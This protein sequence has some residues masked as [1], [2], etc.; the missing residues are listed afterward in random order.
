VGTASAPSRHF[1]RHWFASMVLPDSDVPGEKVISE[2][3]QSLTAG[4]EVLNRLMQSYGF[5]YTATTVG[6]GSGGSFAA[7]ETCPERSEGTMPLAEKGRGDRAQ[8]FAPPQ[9]TETPESEEHSESKSFW[10][11]RFGWGV[12]GW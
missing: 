5:V 10:R 8:S 4:V 9:H 1:A 7:G 11:N 12:A 3:L 6:V 2:A